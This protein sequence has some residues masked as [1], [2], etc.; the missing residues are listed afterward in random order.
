[1]A[2]RFTLDRQSFEQFLAAASLVQ[3]FQK[4]AARAG[5]T[6]AF[7]QPLLELVDTQKAIDTGAMDVDSA[8]ERIVRLA[9]R[10]VGGEGT[11]VWLFS[12]D[13]FV[14]RAG[15]GRNAAQDER[16]RLTVLARVAAICEPSRESF[17]GQ[18]EWA[19]GAGDSGYYP[20]AVRSLIV[21]PIYQNQTVVGA[22]AAFSSAFEVF[23]QRD[24]GNIRLLSGL[25]GSAMER[26]V[27]AQTRTVVALPRQQVLR[28]IEQIV[29]TLQKLVQKEEFAATNLPMSVGLQE[30]PPAESGAQQATTL[31]AVPAEKVEEVA[32]LAP[33]LELSPTATLENVDLRSQTF[34]QDLDV[35]QKEPEPVLNTAALTD[36]LARVSRNLAEIQH[37]EQIAESTAEL[38]S[39]SETVNTRDATFYTERPQESLTTEVPVAQNT[40]STFDEEHS[41][42]APEFTI[43]DTAVPGIGVR[44]ALY[45][46]E[47][48]EPSQF[49][50]NARQSFAEA[51]HFL[52][53]V[54]AAIALG[55]TRVGSS[56]SDTGHSFGRRVRQATSYRPELPTLPTH[57]LAETYREAQT[58]FTSAASRARDRILGLT[59]HKAQLPS[60]SFA[61]LRKGLQVAAGA[62]RESTTSAAGRVN[63]FVNSLPDLPGFPTTAA[64]QQLRHAQLSTAESFKQASA[65]VG[66]I[67]DY[68]LRVRFN[69]RALR[70]SASAF[71]VLVV[72]SSF[73]IMESGLFRS[74]TTA[75]ASARETRSSNAGSGVSSIDGSAA[76]PSASQGTVARQVN[77]TTASVTGPTSHGT[78]TDPATEDIVQNL[79]RYEVSTLRRQAASGDEEAA[80]QLGM[81]YEIGYDLS[82]NCSKAAEWVTKSAE[83][84]YPP[85]QYNLG[86]RYRVGDGVAANAA[87]SGKWLSKAAAR[88]YRPARAALAALTAQDKPAGK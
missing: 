81:A 46:D 58:A 56:L 11:A 14:Y 77:A 71:A 57:R 76:A 49:W 38:M 1:M 30:A 8:I 66:K 25:I 39:L 37:P 54:F 83:A 36:E 26:S 21:G 67:Q 35:Q 7:A 47:A 27:A 65:K 43:D 29:P 9:L 4:Q 78:I 62:L 53:R 17:P 15:S 61:P 82:Q 86:L 69:G 84:G 70:R 34:A 60:I 3:Q 6:D 85:A 22:L 28:L 32:P 45:D 59:K 31:E 68:S 16:L 72:M 5:R 74:D 13:E 88:R 52:R 87:E 24:A 10:V 33:V 63:S 44:A 20:G 40:E 50:L 51:G 18:R 80:F 48:K 75:A 2:Q 41:A 64:K 42:T 23:D 73:L 55:F 19:K 12:N 79:T